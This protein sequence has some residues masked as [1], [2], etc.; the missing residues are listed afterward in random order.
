MTA[1]EWEAPRRFANLRAPWSFLPAQSVCARAIAPRA[2]K[3]ETEGTKVWRLG[4]RR[5]LERYG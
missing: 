5:G 3:C 1:L 4:Y 2:A